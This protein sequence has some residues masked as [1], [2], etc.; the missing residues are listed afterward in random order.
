MSHHRLILVCSL[1]AAV[2][3]T[4]CGSGERVATVTGSVTCDGKPAHG[5]IVLFAPVDDPAA[6]GRPQGQPGRTSTALVGPDG[7]FSLTMEAL[8]Q[9]PEQRGALVGPHHVMFRPPRTTPWELNNLDLALPAEE[10]A[11]LKAE[12]AAKPVYQPLSCGLDITPNSVSVKDGA[13]DFEFKLDHL[14][15]Q[16]AAAAAK[17]G[18]RGYFTGTPSGPVK[19][20]PGKE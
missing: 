16:A 19:V 17:P 5:G 12:L 3:L 13:N 8:G 2:R 20:T 7:R 1:A 6:T 9:E 11:K 10:L 14:S 4:G 15:P 18:K